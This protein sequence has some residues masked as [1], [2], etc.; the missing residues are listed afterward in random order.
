MIQEVVQEWQNLSP[1]MRYYLGAVAVFT[2][3]GVP[4]VLVRHHKAGLEMAQRE[5]E[6]FGPASEPIAL[7]LED[8][9]LPRVPEVTQSNY[10]E[11]QDS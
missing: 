4:A 11:A 8:Q 6:Q 2:A 9:Q 10:L 3:V 1:G 7:P 5:A